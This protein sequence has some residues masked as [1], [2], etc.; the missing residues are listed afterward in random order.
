MT[1]G[2][3]EKVITALYLPWFYYPPAAQSGL[4]CDIHVHLK[5]GYF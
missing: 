4:S 3:G 2:A 5:T 1:F